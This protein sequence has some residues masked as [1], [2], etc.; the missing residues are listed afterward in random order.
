[1][2]LAVG[3]EPPAGLVDGAAVADA[4][5]DVLEGAAFGVVIV[6]LIGGQKGDGEITRDGLQVLLI[7]SG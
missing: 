5:E 6:D 4:G 1:M 2:A 3:E 7:W